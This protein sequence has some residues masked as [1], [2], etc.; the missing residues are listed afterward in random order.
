MFT[1]LDARRQEQLSHINQFVLTSY[2]LDP[3][4]DMVCH[5]RMR[6]ILFRPSLESSCNLDFPWLCSP[7]ALRLYSPAVRRRTPSAPVTTA[8]RST[9]RYVSRAS[10][11]SVQQIRIAKQGSPA[12]RTNACQSRPPQ[13]R[14]LRI[15]PLWPR[16]L[17]RAPATMTAP[18][19]SCAFVQAASTSNQGWP[20]AAW[21]AST[22]PSTQLI[23]QPSSSCRA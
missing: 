17:P 7:L 1:E 2:Q 16:P 8:A 18:T 4:V 12:S 5:R 10:A 20:S 15:H 14:R 6:P 9:A 11:R 19:S 21:S 23:P 13:R 3:T 22:S